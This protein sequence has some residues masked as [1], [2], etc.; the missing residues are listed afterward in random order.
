MADTAFR[1]A[2]CEVRAWND[3]AW[4]QVRVR[5]GVPD[6]F[7][8]DPSRMGTFKAG[9]GKGGDLM[10]FTVDGKFIIK[11]LNKGDHEALLR[12]TSSYVERVFTGKSLLCTFYL[13][14]TDPTTDKTYMVMRN[15]LA[16][17]GPYV[18]LYDL[19]GCAD[20][21]T[22][23]VNGRK[24]KAVNKRI[25]HLHMWGGECCW[26]ED[27]VTYY[28]GKVA[29]RRL[30]I[31]VTDEQREA[32]VERLKLDTAW[33]AANSLMDYSL[34]LG[35][36][37][38]SR[39]ELQ[40]DPLLLWAR[41]APPG[42]LRQ[43]LLHLENGNDV[44]LVYVGII[45]FLQTWTSGK[46]VAQCLKVMERNKATIPPT[47]YGQR[48]L[49]HFSRN[50]RGGAKAVE[51]LP[52][53]ADE[54]QPELYVRAVSEA[55]SYYSCHSFEELRELSNGIDSPPAVNGVWKSPSSGRHKA[56]RGGTFCFGG[57]RCFGGLW[58][59]AA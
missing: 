4:R 1:V 55:V 15:L 16:H 12:I 49:E 10:A 35:M 30:A 9:G 37:R 46:R 40:S 51:A 5:D 32:I 13:H 58:R 59:A 38:V 25:W 41:S 2:G 39:A 17:K 23:E 42:E 28:Q 21:K 27:R 53:E 29:A 43:P 26:T 33:L 47:P 11:E 44:M 7:L 6:N 54:A 36:C 19:K 8:A 45:D 22:L 50:I 56:A 3:E 20:D 48:F 52:E 57:G 34:L 31:T 24:V 18:G 14:Y